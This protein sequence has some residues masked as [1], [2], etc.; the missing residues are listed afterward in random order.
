MSRGEKVFVA[1]GSTL[2][3]LLFWAL[4]RQEREGSATVEKATREAILPVVTR[5]WQEIGRRVLVS[6]TLDLAQRSGWVAQPMPQAL[7][8]N[9]RLTIQGQFASSESVAFVVLDAENY[10]RLQQG[11]PPVL[12]YGVRTGEPVHVAWPSAGSW[13]GFA[14]FPAQAGSGRLPTSLT[15]VLVQALAH[16]AAENRP[17]ARVTAELYVVDE[18]F[19]TDAEAAAQKR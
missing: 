14:R 11:Y 19:C 15:D 13:F 8:Q 10:T 2:A 1:V 4:I 17:P 16:V 9:H 3:I 5:H 12:V 7:P 6:Q 18:C